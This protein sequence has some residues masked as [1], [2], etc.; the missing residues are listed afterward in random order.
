VRITHDESA[1]GLVETNYC[2][3]SAKDK[4]VTIM[5]TGCLQGGDT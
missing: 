5:D 1:V 2:R 3:L 4:E